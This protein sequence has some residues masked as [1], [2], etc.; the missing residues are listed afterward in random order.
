LVDAQERE[1]REAF[2]DSWF[3]PEGQ[4]GLRAVAERLRKR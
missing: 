4:A 1:H 2:L 3:S